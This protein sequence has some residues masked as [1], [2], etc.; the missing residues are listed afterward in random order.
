[1][2]TSDPAPSPTRIRKDLADAVVASLREVTG[3]GP[4]GTRVVLTAESLV[5]FLEDSLSAGERAL[6]AAGHEAEVRALRS[7]YQ[8]TMREDLE[9]R[10]SEITG[11]EI[12]AFMSTNHIDPDIAVEIFVYGPPTD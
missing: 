2:T 12:A 4:V 11:R 6:V 10:V 8:Q 7:A 1:V 3:R 5:V 9:E